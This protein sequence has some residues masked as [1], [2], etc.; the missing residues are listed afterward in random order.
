MA[1][2]KYGKSDNNRAKIFTRLLL[3][4]TSFAVIA[5]FMMLFNWLN[6]PKN[7]PFKKVELVNSLKNQES[8]ELQQI[9]AKALNGGFFSLDVDAFRAELLT[10]LPWVKSVSVRKIWPDKLLVEISEYKPI[11]RWHSVG[12]LIKAENR[13]QLLSQDGVIFEPMLT[14]AQK[15]KFDKMALFSGPI[16]AVKKVL[17]KCLIMNESVKLLGLEIKQCGMNKRRTW[18]L[19]LKPKSLLATDLNKKNTIAMNIKL[20]KE[21]IM[22][23]LERFVQVFSGKLKQYL[24]SVEYADLRYSNGFSIKW[25]AEHGFDKGLHKTL[26]QQSNK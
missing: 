6:S 23:Q 21:N 17:E 22:Q 2:D 5:S 13:Y 16:M 4:L 8:S 11:V 9:A 12:A 18:A 15:V 3:L 19:S 26:Q 20:G 25:I 1:I 24:S 7:F 14:A 10:T